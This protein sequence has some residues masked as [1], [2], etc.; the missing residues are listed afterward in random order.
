MKTQGLDYLYYRE[1]LPLGLAVEVFSFDALKEAYKNADN[2]ECLEHV[3]VYMYNNQ[4]KF[5]CKRFPNT[6][7]DYSKYRLTM[8]TKDDQKLVKTLYERLL[9]QK[10]G[11]SYK[12][13]IKELQMH[14]ELVQ[15]NQNIIQKK[16]NYIGEL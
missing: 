8:D 16:V 14:P 1:G 12:D 3:T 9:K 4:H 11:F 7:Y 13:I 15:I 5:H 10:D 6:G 2:Q